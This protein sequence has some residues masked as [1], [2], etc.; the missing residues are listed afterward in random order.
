MSPLGA[1]SPLAEWRRTPLLI[2]A[3]VALGAFYSMVYLGLSSRWWFEDDPSLFAY[4]AEL[5]SPADAFTNPEVLRHF[6][7]GSALV[8]MQLLSYWVDVRL[9]RYSPRF[10]YGH[11]TL[12]FLL[13]LVFL[14]LALRQWLQDDLAAFFASAIWAVL[15]T[16]AVVLQYLATRHY[17]EGMLFT[18]AAL[19][20]L[21]RLRRGSRL[22]W[23]AQVAVLSCAIVGMLYKEVYAA[24]TPMILL[25]S[26]WR[27]RDW[28]FAG[29]IAATAC[30]YAIY[31]LWI[32]G[33]MLTYTDMPWLSPGQYARFLTKL[34]YTFSSNYGGYCLIGIIAALAVCAARSRRKPAVLCFAAVLA[35]SLAAILPVSYPLYGTIRDPGPW[36]R[37]VFVPHS[38]AVAFAA[39]FVVRRQRRREK[40][41]LVLIAFAVLLPGVEKTRR[42]WS[43]M[44]SSAER[45][46]RFYLDNP[47]KLLLSEQGEGWWFIPGIHWMYGLENEHYVLLKDVATTQI[48]PAVPIWRYKDGAF[49]PDYALGIRNRPAP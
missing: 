8:P 31:R 42:L 7:S 20:L 30:A 11:Q 4:A 24:M 46:G 49:A 34:P 41:A 15:P 1:L 21:L 27:R 28:K 16:T 36:H 44:T 10:A 3:L 18:V 33:P 13:T 32:L 19:Y 38:A 14:C 2:A 29:M 5:H 9:A 35:V 12:S 43:D 37:I 48:E 26:A 6:T 47:D 23:G 40:A 45:E 22:T 17:L 25:A 39:Y